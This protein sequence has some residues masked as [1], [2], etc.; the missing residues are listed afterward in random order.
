MR[1][2]TKVQPLGAVKVLHDSAHGYKSSM[3][4]YAWDSEDT[5]IEKGV[6]V[7]IVYGLVKAVKTEL[8]VQYE[9]EDYGSE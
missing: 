2:W 9:K 1:V 8:R 3:K 4:I 5:E 6:A 7:A